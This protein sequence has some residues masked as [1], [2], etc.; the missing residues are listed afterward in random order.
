MAL[1]I[2]NVALAV[3]TT[4]APDDDAYAP[5]AGC[6]PKQE[7]FAQAWAST[8]NKSAAYRIAYNVHPRTLPNVVWVSAQ[9][10]S[11]LPQVIARYKVLVQQAALDTIMSVRELYALQVDIATA[12][13]TEVVKVVSR[14]CRYCHGDNYKYQ[15]RDD[16]EYMAACIT[17]LDAKQPPPLDE[18]GYGFNGAVEPE[19]TC[20]HCYGVG[21][22]QKIITPSDKLTGKARKL[23]AGAF[24]GKEGR[25][26]VKLHDQQKAAE[27]A[28]RIAGA[29]ND[30]LDLRTPDERERAEQHRTL[31]ANVTS[32]T[33]A[34]AYLSLLN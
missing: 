34:K 9:R 27:L 13:P 6:T 3:V 16:E 32:E 12:D 4:P 1:R 8:G 7:A 11:E 21:F 10:V 2:N 28:G 20:P 31:P 25:I 29:F 22:E 30:K 18:G 23:Y 15:W 5:S 19:P 14:N 17:A 24:Y 26:E 33:A